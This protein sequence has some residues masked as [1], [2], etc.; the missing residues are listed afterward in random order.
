MSSWGSTN[1]AE[2]RCFLVLS[3]TSSQ[4]VPL[5]ASLGV[6][7][8][9]VGL[10]TVCTA[11]CH[12]CVCPLSY[13]IWRGFVFLFPTSRGEFLT[14]RLRIADYPLTRG[15]EIQKCKERKRFILERFHVCPF[16]LRERLD[17]G[18]QDDRAVYRYVFACPGESEILVSAVYH[19]ERMHPCQ[20]MG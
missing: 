13:G 15:S 12:A 14:T 10:H 2:S 20:I 6:R 3:I 17:N 11:V 8:H 16:V 5:M 9:R 7:L 4:H 19:R 18:S 1:S